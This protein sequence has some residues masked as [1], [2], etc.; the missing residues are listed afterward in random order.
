ME[1]PSYKDY[2]LKPISETNLELF[3]CDSELESYFKL[4]AQDS[5][6]ELISKNYFLHCNGIEEPLVGF[7]LSNSA[8]NTVLEFRQIIPHNTQ[9]KAYPAVLIGRFATHS[10]YQGN[11]F[12]K[13]VLGLLKSW[14]ITNNKTGC[15]FL[16]V[17][18]RKE[19]V[20]FYKNS[21]F[22][23]YPEQP[24]DSNN[25][26]MYFDLKDFQLEVRKRI[27]EN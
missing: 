5:E 2:F 26:L 24:P 1:L 8:I 15:R 19:A 12:G 4:D 13:I 9:Y 20:N 27:P 22:E 11:G 17:D 25:I 18:A 14:F 16:I 6:S 23:D 3:Q 10:K 7:C 21:G